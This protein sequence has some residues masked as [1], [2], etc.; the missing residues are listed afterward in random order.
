M[1][2]NRLLIEMKDIRKEFSGVVVLDDVNFDLRA[3][4]VHVL[5]G[6]NGA[7][8]STLI[9]I[10][11]GIYSKDGGEMLLE[12]K[13]FEASCVHEA[14]AAGIRIIHQELSLVPKLTVAE[15]IYLGDEPRKGIFV[16][17]SKMYE[18]VQKWIDDMGLTLNAHAEIDT[19]TIAEQ[20]MVEVIRAISF[21]AKVIVMDEPTSSL[22]DRE[23]ETLFKYIMMLKKQGIGIIYISHRMSELQQI[24]DRVSVLRDGKCVGT[25]EM[26]NTTIDE[27]VSLMVGRN[28]ENFYVKK[29]AKTDEVLLEVENLT[30][31]YVEDV[32]FVLHK[33]EIL[34]FSGLVGAGRTETMRAIFG[35][36]KIHS[37]TIKIAGN[38]I[39]IHSPASAYEAGIAMITEDRKLSGLFMGQAIRF[40]MTIRSCRE[41]IKGIRIDSRRESELSG[42][43]YNRL[44]VRATGDMA[45]VSELSG[46]NQQKVVIGGVLNTNPRILIM[47]EPTRGIDVGA[48]A[49]IY[50]IMSELAEAGMAII[51]VSSELPE[52]LNISDRIVVMCNGK[53]TATMDAENATEE[54]IMRKAVLV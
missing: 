12:G 42:M 17:Y 47:D 39:K 50:A 51:M 11:G 23:I 28:I 34:G 30:T 2:N 43:Q 37:G 44:N 26:K 1:E 5:V 9:K 16:N 54:A 3:G 38:E 49:E 40:N 15:N 27:L 31:D 29:C 41:F 13:T 14:S 52:I 18:D 36:D 46:G 19:L 25:K 48:K 4:E 45:A 32:S 35:I 10:M 24:A 33:G 8:K 7:G 53:V 6:E 20:Q 22:T 21:G